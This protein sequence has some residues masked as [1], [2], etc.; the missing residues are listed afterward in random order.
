M[1]QETGEFKDDEDITIPS[2]D[3]NKEVPDVPD[4]DIHD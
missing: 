3:R 1:Q 2:Q 4:S